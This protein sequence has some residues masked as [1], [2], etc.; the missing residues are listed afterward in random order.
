MEEDIKKNEE[1]VKKNAIFADK[2]D[3]KKEKDYVEHVVDELKEAIGKYNVL[4]MAAP[5]LGYYSRIICVKIGDE[6]KEFVNPV[7]RRIDGILFRKET[8]L[9]LEDINKQY[10]VPRH[11]E[12]DIYY[13][14]KRGK[15]GCCTLKAEAA[16]VF[17]QLYDILQ[18]VYIDDLYDELP[19]NFDNF[20]DE[21]L[22]NYLNE[23]I[24]KLEG[25]QEQL[26]KE[27]D[28]DPELSDI[29]DKL[30]KYQEL[31]L[32]ELRERKKKGTINREQRRRIMKE[33]KRRKK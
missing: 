12:V 33:V 32:E 14:N 26:E 17:E 1:I 25:M 27:I 28:E 5:Q 21:E 4:G 16:G 18:G 20:T 19:E 30:K 15:M 7:I 2:I 22:S 9:S 11:S 23:Y 24:K 10:L 6:I 8:S 31:S 13:Q 29:R 3:T